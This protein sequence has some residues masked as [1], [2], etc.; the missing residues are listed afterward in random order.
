MSLQT[1]PRLHACAAVAGFF[2]AAGLAQAGV[3]YE[4]VERDLPGGQETAVTTIQVQD[5]SMRLD[6]L[7]TGQAAPDNGMIFTGEAIIGIDHRKKQYTHMDRAQL[8]QLAGQVN[9]AMKEMEAQL[10][11]M[12]PEQRAM[13][14]KMM[15]RN[16]PGADKPRRVAPTFTRTSRTE[17]AAG[18]SCQVWEGHRDGRKVTEHCIVPYARLTGGSEMGEVM[19]NMTAMM[20]ELLASMDSPRLEGIVRN[21]WE[22]LRTI[23]GY[24]VISRTFTDGKATEEHALRSARLASVPATQLAPP[25]GYERKDLQPQ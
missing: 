23:D 25:A 5:G 2:C 9:E 3:V 10:A 24:P 16:I 20:D 19:K 17:S 15:G 22:G 1:L 18:Y 6:T 14:E 13:V 11:S 8:K 4:T 12:S 7:K 21:E